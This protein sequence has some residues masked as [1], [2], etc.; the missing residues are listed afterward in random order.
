[1][2]K[3]ILII[4]T[5]PRKNGNSEM[6]ANSF[7][8]GAESVG[9]EVE[10]VCL[11]DKTIGFCKGCLYCQKT[12]RCLIHDDADVIA[13][14]MGKADIIVFVTPIYYYEMSGQMKTMLDR[15]NPLYVSDYNF[16]EI[17]LL[18]TA[19]DDEPTAMD[20]AIKGLEGWVSCFEKAELKGVVKGLNADGIGTIK[21]NSAIDEAFKMGAAIK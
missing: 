9:N 10:K 17:Y 20:G 5:S 2:S 7:A 14:K 13:Q 15:S 6:L 21:G 19:A 4:S 12:K 3:K 16:R 11:Y 8:R 18:A 1:M